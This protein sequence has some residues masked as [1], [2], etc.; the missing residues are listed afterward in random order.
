[1]W[2]AVGVVRCWEKASFLKETE[3]GQANNN[4]KKFVWL[5]SIPLYLLLS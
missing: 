2:Q 5:Q 4:N 3:S 1:M